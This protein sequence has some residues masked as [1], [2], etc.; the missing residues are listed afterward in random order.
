ME[1]LDAPATTAAE[2]RE[3]GVWMLGGCGTSS[4]G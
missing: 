4:E 1:R 3:F 2:R